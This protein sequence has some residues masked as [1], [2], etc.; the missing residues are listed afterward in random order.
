MHFYF[1]FFTV[2]GLTG[3]KMSS[4]VEDSKIDLLDS[5]SALKKKLKKA[6]CE[7]GNVKD[8][9][10]LSFCQHVLFP[11]RGKEGKEVS[12]IPQFVFKALPGMYVI[13]HKPWIRNKKIFYN[14]QMQGYVS[15]E[16]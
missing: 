11:L 5:P 10:V 7:P 4:S 3:D 1:E 9:G 15:L 8:N 2:P 12:N 13:S 14:V 16:E 6:F